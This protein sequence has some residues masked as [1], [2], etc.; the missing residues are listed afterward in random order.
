M[1]RRWVGHRSNL[2][3]HP[4]YLVIAC[5]SASFLLKSL[6]ATSRDSDAKVPVQGLSVSPSNLTRDALW[7]GIDAGGERN[8][9]HLSGRQFTDCECKGTLV[10][11]MSSWSQGDVFHA[12]SFA[13]TCDPS[14]PGLRSDTSFFADCTCLMLNEIVH[15]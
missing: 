8:C 4:S 1:G 7:T 6:Q 13:A 9:S 12:A 5:I 14:S 2:R 15:H 11:A 10:S 3:G